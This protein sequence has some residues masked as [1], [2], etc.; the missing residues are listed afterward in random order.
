MYREWVPVGRLVLTLTL[1]F[2]VL[3]VFIVAASIVAGESSDID[4]GTTLV[5]VMFILAILWNFRGL[6][7]EVDDIGV[8]VKYGMLNSKRILFDEIVSCE[9]VESTFGKYLGVGIRYGRDGS[10]AY[11]TSFGSAVKISTKE[12]RPFVFSTHHP[13]D[14]CRAILN[15]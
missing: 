7:I 3:S 8:T 9:P 15:E 10:F 13:E 5:P 14:V 1:F 12:G 6:R 4:I 11:T 2:I